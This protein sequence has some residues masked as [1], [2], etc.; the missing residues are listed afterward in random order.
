MVTVSYHRIVLRISFVMLRFGGL[1]CCW[2]L[3]T[4][5]TTPFPF[6]ICQLLETPKVFSPPLL[7]IPTLPFRPETSRFR[8]S[9]P[10]SRFRSIFSRFQ[11]QLSPPAKKDNNFPASLFFL[12]RSFIVFLWYLGLFFTFTFTKCSVRRNLSSLCRRPGS[13]ISSTFLLSFPSSNKR[14]KYL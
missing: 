1:A 2:T 4:G 7:E 13:S 6:L 14:Y 12:A 10:A 8:R 5:K 9:F 3:F 11:L